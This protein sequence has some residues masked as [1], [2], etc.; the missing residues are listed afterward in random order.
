M[1]VFYPVNQCFSAL[2]VEKNK[3]RL[4]IFLAKIFCEIIASYFKIKIILT[5]RPHYLKHY[6]LWRCALIL[7]QHKRKSKL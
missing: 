2:F 3:K 4:K 5:Y 7:I 6:E 1:D